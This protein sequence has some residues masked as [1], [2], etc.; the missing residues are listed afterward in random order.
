[1]SKE[2]F[3]DDF[4]AH[5][6]S[7]KYALANLD[8]DD[9]DLDDESGRKKKGTKTF[10]IVLVVLLLSGGAFFLGEHFNSNGSTKIVD[11]IVEGGSVTKSGV[12]SESELR[13]LVVSAHLTAYW[14]GPIDG[15]KYT[16]YVPKT[17]VVV[18]RYLPNGKGLEDTSPKYRV[19]GTYA[20]KDATAAVQS[21]GKKDGSVGFTN[22]DGNAIFY[23]RGTTHK[24][25]HGYKR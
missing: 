24:C 9:L 21:S 3:G 13:D 23:V 12:L 2:E 18:V 17:G 1:M 20:Q 16:L 14:A 19:I 11:G 8:D 4:T 25:L 22:I 10:L 5:M 7:Q 6:N 15:Y